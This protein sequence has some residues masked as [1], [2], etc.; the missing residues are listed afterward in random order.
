MAKNQ[1]KNFAVFIGVG[2]QMLMIIVGG[3]FLGIWLDGKFISWSP[4]FTIASS[5]ISVFL[6]L[7]Y[8][9]RKLNK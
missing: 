1:L 4:A 5:L 9:L 7:Y 6:A 2:M 3:T 8:V